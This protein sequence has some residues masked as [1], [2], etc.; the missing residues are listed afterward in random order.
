M[1]REEG[2]QF[3]IFNA[4]ARIRQSPVAIGEDERL[5]PF[6]WAGTLGQEPRKKN[7]IKE[8]SKLI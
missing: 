5:Y 7:T 3:R 1:C 4:R 2:G 6:G 8:A